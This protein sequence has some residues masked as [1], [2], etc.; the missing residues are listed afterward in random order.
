LRTAGATITWR[1]TA[2]TFPAATARV[3]HLHDEETRV[4]ER[5]G[6]GGSILIVDAG[7][8][9]ALIVLLEIDRRGEVP[10]LTSLSAG[11]DPEFPQGGLSARWPGSVFPPHGT[12]ELP[13]ADLIALARYALV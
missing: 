13:M 5:T 8:V 7:P 11:V 9:G 1:V 6:P 3:A 2:T 4:E 10:L 12:P